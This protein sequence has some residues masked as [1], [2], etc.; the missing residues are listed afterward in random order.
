MS[1]SPKPF[2]GRRM[3]FVKEYIIDCNATQAAIRAGYSAKT[4][5][6]QAS[7]LL[8]NLDIEAAIA[9][10]KAKVA[11]RVEL[12]QEYV[13][14]GLIANHDRAM[15]LVEVTDKKGQPTGEFRYEGA[16]AN[17]SLELLGKHLAMFTDVKK[18]D[19]SEMPTLGV[20]I[21]RD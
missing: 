20:T 13:L 17:R 21:E 8:T 4:A 19:L 14:N 1:D 18:I 3:R 7:K 10:E 16:V 12:T 5:R 6:Q 11:E 9:I 2:N 15:Q